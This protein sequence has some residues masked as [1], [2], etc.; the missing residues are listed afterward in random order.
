[1]LSSARLVYISIYKLLEQYLTS[2]LLP[3]FTSHKICIL[4]MAAHVIKNEYE[5]KSSL[6]QVASASPP[7]VIRVCSTLF[8]GTSLE[9]RPADH[10]AS[11]AFGHQYSITTAFLLSMGYEDNEKLL[12]W[13]ALR[14]VYIII[15]WTFK[16]YKRP[17]FKDRLLLIADDTIAIVF[18]QRL[19]RPW[20]LTNFLHN[21][22]MAQETAVRASAPQVR[23]STQ[24]HL[25]CYRNRSRETA[26]PATR[27]PVL[28]EIENMGQTTPEPGALVRRV[29]DDVHRKSA[30][31][32]SQRLVEIWKRYA[33]EKF[34]DTGDTSELLVALDLSQQRLSSQLQRTTRNTSHGG[35]V[36]R[37]R[38]P[39]KTHRRWSSSS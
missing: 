38:G 15:E 24:N 33:E 35:R 18:A 27:R 19:D 3:H 21:F 25:L 12:K 9:P 13:A 8:H 22:D 20:S 4:E 6:L 16:E 23:R 5:N 31:Q 17:V 7:N 1:M 28:S 29:S 37:Q 10:L 36:N 26:H 30:Q 34:R 39:H 32:T 11:V 2:S 14:T